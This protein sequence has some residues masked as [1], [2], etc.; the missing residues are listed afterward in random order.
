MRGRRVWVAVAGGLIVL[1]GLTLLFLDGRRPAQ[2]RGDGPAQTAATSPSSPSPSPE[3]IAPD[4]SSPR[5]LAAILTLSPECELGQPLASIFEQ[6]VVIDPETFEASRGRPVAVPGFAEPIAPRFVRRVQPLEP[7]GH[8]RHVSAGLP[9]R[10]VWHGLEVTA[11][12]FDFYEE[13][14]VAGRRIRFA[15]SPERTR[16]ILSRNGFA[17]PPVGEFRE[18]EGEGM[19]PSIG[20]ERL[21]NGSALTCTTG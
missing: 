19:L 21:P 11:V 16:E 17:L 6:I 15:D 10:G 14:D 3:A 2:P 20:I 13:S 1:A 8:L 5:D 4:P 18:M 7:G 12:E 9:L